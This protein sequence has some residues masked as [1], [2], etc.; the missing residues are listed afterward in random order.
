MEHRGGKLK[1][2]FCESL[3]TSTEIKGGVRKDF[4]VVVRRNEMGQLWLALK[5]LI[6]FRFE[7]KLSE[8]SLFS[9]NL[10]AYAP[11]KISQKLIILIGL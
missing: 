5:L 10:S 6:S 8:N 7:S 11:F 4:K 1:W 9:F 2:L 3:E